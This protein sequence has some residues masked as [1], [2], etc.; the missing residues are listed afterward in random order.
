M[1]NIFFTSD[2]HFS[3][4]NIAK[5][6]PH[7]RPATSDIAELDEFMIAQWNST[8]SPDDI[9]YNLGDVSFAHDFPRIENVLRRLNGQHHL[10]YGNHDGQIIQHRQRLLNTPKNDGHPILSSVQYYLKLRLPEASQ[11]LVLFHYPIQE[12]DGCHKGWYHLYG[13]LHDRIAPMAGRALN[14][15]YDL[16]G[17][18]LNLADIEYFLSDL[19]TVNRFGAERTCAPTAASIKAQMKT[20]CAE[21]EWI[22]KNC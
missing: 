9:V 13:H 5:F 12:W 8:V 14:V 10:I 6:C 19:P 16:H 2:L 3:H 11:T 4:K 20:Y 17:R 1:S 7:F 22:A 15:G 21:R 18:L